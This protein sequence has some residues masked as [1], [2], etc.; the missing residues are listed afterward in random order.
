RRAFITTLHAAATARHGP[1]QVPA[2]LGVLGVRADFEGRCAGYPQ[3]AGPGQDR[4]L[5]TPMTERPLRM[6]ITEPAKKAGSKGDDDLTDLLLAE[7]R[8]GQPGSFGAGAL[9]LLSH[10]LDQAWRSR[11]GAPVTLADYE[12]AGGIDGAVAASAQHAYDALTPAQQSAARQVFL[13]LT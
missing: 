1:D 11:T 5:V 3:L 6:A 12:R 7:V 10:A 13:R 2:A 4:D 8:T 9:P